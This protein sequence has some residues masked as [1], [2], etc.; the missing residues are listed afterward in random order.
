VTECLPT[1]FR[2]EYTTK[3]TE[4]QIDAGAIHRFANLT[5]SNKLGDPE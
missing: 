1:C 4:A 2:K 5:G 3:I